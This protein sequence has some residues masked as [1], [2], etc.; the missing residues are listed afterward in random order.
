MFTWD[1]RLTQPNQDF[2][3]LAAAHSIEHML[4]TFAPRHIPHFVDV[5]PMGCLTGYHLTTFNFDSYEGMLAGLFKT[6]GDCLEA[7]E[8]PHANVQDCGWAANHSL[9]GAKAIARSALERRDDWQT[10]FK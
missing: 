1:I 10:I 4:L 8:V 7:T 6:F 9:E 5:R 3:D 2:L